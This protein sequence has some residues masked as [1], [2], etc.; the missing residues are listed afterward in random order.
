MRCLLIML[1]TA[2]ELH[3]SFMLREI[4]NFQYKFGSVTNLPRLLI[5]KNEG[6]L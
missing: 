1:D 3:N 4:A 2:I 6:K 5:E